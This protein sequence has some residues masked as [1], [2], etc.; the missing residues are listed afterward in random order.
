MG[1]ELVD[2]CLRLCVC[3]LLHKCVGKWEKNTFA[4][5]AAMDGG[6][7]PGRFIHVFT[8]YDSGEKYPF[9]GSATLGTLS[10]CFTVYAHPDFLVQST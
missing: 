7:C 9:L 1:A 3:R 6:S 4:L 2:F 5:Y 10:A 8:G